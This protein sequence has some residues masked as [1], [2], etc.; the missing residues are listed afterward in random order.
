MP[1]LVLARKRRESKGFAGYVE[2]GGDVPVLWLIILRMRRVSMKVS[3]VVTQTT[4][5]T[6]IITMVSILSPPD[7]LQEGI[8]SY[9]ARIQNGRLLLRGCIIRVPGPVAGF[10][11]WFFRRSWLS[12]A[13]R[14]SRYNQSLCLNTPL[15]FL[16]T[17]SRKT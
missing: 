13:H 10:P 7:A 2:L 12:S 6:M 11:P 5:P 4:L 16:F 1:M 15:S 9:V 17:T 8:F 14:Q 3:A